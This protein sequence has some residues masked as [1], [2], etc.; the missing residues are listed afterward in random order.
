MRK[1]LNLSLTLI[2]AF[3]LI[4]CTPSLVE[5]KEYTVTFELHNG[6]DPIT[7]K[8]LENQLVE[9]PVEP[10][11]DGYEFDNW[12]KDAELTQIWVFAADRVT[13]DVTIHAGWTESE[14]EEAYN[15]DMW[16]ESSYVNVLREM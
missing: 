4:A 11:Y 1:I 16:I 15:I 6:Q 3:I 13:S 9:E 7:A 2:L 10:T 8:Y 14:L 5:D 12:Y